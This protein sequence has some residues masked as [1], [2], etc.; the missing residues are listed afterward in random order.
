M[1]RSGGVCWACWVGTCGSWGAF[2][3][4]ALCILRVWSGCLEVVVEKAFRVVWLDGR[5]SL[6]EDAASLKQRL[7]ILLEDMV[8]V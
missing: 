8:V 4:V 7:Q 2:W 3:E 5:D 1:S 6:E